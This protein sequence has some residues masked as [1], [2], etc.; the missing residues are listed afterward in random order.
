MFVVGCHRSG[1][2]LLASLLSDALATDH[3]PQGEA[4]EIALDNPRGFYESKR[5][6][7]LNDQLLSSIGC[8]WDQPPLL[9]PDWS[10]KQRIDEFCALRSRFMEQALNPA[11][12]DKD[13]RLCLTY[14]AFAH[15]LLRRVH[16]AVIVRDPLEVATSLYL[17]NGMAIERGLSLWFLYNHHLAFHLQQGDQLF[18]YRE[19][20]KLKPG[21][22]FFDTVFNA[23]NHLLSEVRQ[24][25]LSKQQFEQIT[26]K[27]ISPDLNRS[28]TGLPASAAGD[29]A[30]SRLMPMCEQAIARW[31]L[32]TSP[33]EG[34][35]DAFGSI[36]LVL[37]EVLSQN[38]W[39]GSGMPPTEAH[40]T[41]NEVDTELL[42][43]ELQ[44]LHEQLNKMQSSTSWR[45][46]QPV[47]WLGDRLWN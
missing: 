4:L 7:T 38:Q 30:C 22:P 25:A 36:P 3:Q 17:R 21:M 14:A 15:I 5:L 8:S 32:S 43:R 41:T 9:P 35:K 40:P 16:L 19:L 39:Y 31:R 45:F 47:R 6:Q 26:A 12:V 18:D 11:W 24:P 44:R 27:R 23:I 37:S 28:A 33:I 42:E 13:P 10:P 2:S 20:H 46:T 34:W 29:L 1:T